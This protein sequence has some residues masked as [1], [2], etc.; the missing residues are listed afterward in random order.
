[1]KTFPGSFQRKISFHEVHKFNIFCKLPITFLHIL[2]NVNGNILIYAMNM[3]SSLRCDLLFFCL[4]V[5]KSEYRK[6]MYT[7]N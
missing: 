1:M 3:V 4:H 6:K 5:G 7:M 2:H